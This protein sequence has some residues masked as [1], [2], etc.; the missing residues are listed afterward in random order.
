M[1]VNTGLGTPAH[2]G[3]PETQLAI[4]CPL[5]TSVFPAVRPETAVDFRI[6]LL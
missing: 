4:G 1:V 6:K 5:K 3:M 2:P